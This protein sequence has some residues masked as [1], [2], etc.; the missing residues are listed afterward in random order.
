[1]EGDTISTSA[2]DLLADLCL[3]G[4][5]CMRFGMGKPRS[6]GDLI[7]KALREIDGYN[8]LNVHQGNNYVGSHMSRLWNWMIITSDRENNGS[9]FV[10]RELSEHRGDGEQRLQLREQARKKLENFAPLLGPP[11]NTVH[12][13]ARR[14]RLRNNQMQYLETP[15]E[16]FTGHV[17]APGVVAE[18]RT[19]I[20]EADVKLLRLMF[21]PAIMCNVVLRSGKLHSR[22]AWVGQPLCWQHKFLTRNHRLTRWCR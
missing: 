4:V 15:P 11:E 2:Q 3:V 18:R 1:M 9:S 7:V 6:M 13:V 10:E 22:R 19:A 16:I 14:V 12:Q 5:L 20:R 17:V 8:G 21:P